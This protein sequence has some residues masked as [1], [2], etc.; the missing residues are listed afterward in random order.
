MDSKGIITVELIFASFLILIIAVS[1]LSVVSSRMDATSS[2]DELGNARMTA[3]NVAESI[4]KVYSN[5]NGHTVTVSLPANISNKNYGIK[6]NSSG[7]FVLIDGD[8]GK[9]FIN[10][11][12]ISSSDKLIESTV[13]MHCNCNYLIKNVKGPDGN[14]W[15]VISPI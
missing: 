15:I 14:N 5:G 8:I 7:I 2:T 12:K 13:L 11:K 6:V 9:S 1:I 10:P 3:E 4:N